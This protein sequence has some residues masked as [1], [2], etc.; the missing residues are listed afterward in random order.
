MSDPKVYCIHPRC[1]CPMPHSPQECGWLPPVTPDEMTKARMTFE[2]WPP[3]TVDDP[4][5]PTS[6]DFASP[7]SSR[8]LYGAGPGD[9]P[10]SPSRSEI[11]SP[12]P[13][14]PVLRPVRPDRPRKPGGI[15]THTGRYVST[16]NLAV[17]DVTVTDIAHG[18]ALCNRFVGQTAYPLSVAQHS[19]FVS[20]LVPPAYRLQ[21]LFHDA[22]E[23]YLGDMTKWLK[24][25]DEMAAYREVE[26]RTQDTIYRALG[27]PTTEES[28]AAVDEA[29]KLMVRYEAFMIWGPDMPLFDRPDYPVPT[30][31]E[32]DLVESLDISWGEWNWRTAER[33]FHHAYFQYTK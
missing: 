5:Y 16:L 20:R 6:P 31:E 11:V 13:A 33:E 4:I 29:D 9:R 1:T 3:A 2:S 22:S 23:A 27:I 14:E 25:T 8:L 18:L 17:E 26:E 10:A 12:A 24:M 19:I 15:C 28:N 7:E 32:R 21:G 30:Q